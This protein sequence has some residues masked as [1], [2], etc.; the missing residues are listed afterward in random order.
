MEI[1]YK[2]KFSTNSCLTGSNPSAIT[3]IDNQGNDTCD[4]EQAA[5]INHPTFKNVHL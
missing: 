5:T 3:Y 4:I 1:S 2:R